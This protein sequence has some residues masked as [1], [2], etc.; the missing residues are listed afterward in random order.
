MSL[1]ILK[2]S[3]SGYPGRHQVFLPH[4]AEILCVRE[5]FDVP[6]LWCRAD[7]TLPYEWRTIE[8]CETGGEA[9]HGRFLGTVLLAGGT[10]VFHA[11]EIQGE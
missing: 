1:T 11:F 3:L 6:T 4:G 9:S 7:T 5:Q 2:F 10:L 8:L